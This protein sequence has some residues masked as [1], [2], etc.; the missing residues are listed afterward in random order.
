MPGNVDLVVADSKG[1][2]KGSVSK[3]TLELRA[4]SGVW[5]D[6]QQTGVVGINSGITYTSDPYY[7]NMMDN[8]IAGAGAY[9][10]FKGWVGSIG[11]ATPNN[12]AIGITGD[13]CM[14]VGG[15]D[16]KGVLDPLLL[17]DSCPPCVDCWS[18]RQ[19]DGSPTVDV[20]DET[21][22]TKT[23]QVAIEGLFD[24]IERLSAAMT[25]HLSGMLGYGGILDKYKQLVDMY[26]YVVHRRSYAC[27]VDMYG[28]SSHASFR[29]T[30]QSDQLAGFRIDIEFPKAPEFS[31]AAFIDASTTKG[32]VISH[33]D[34]FAGRG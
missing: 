9:T 33:E 4:G 23:T 11:G 2:P 16:K 31:K 18:F 13:V 8:I 29:Y 28:R 20:P 22:P 5:L 19:G 32:T 14:A 34:D 24:L 27:S 10:G 17:K 1:N 12:G 7:Q 15:V 21:D 6:A 26:N 30:N 3:G 25:T